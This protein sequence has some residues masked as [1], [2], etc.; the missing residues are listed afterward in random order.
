[1]SISAY[2]KFDKA[3]RRISFY[4]VNMIACHIPVTF[5]RLYMKFV[6]SQLTEEEKKQLV[7]RTGIYNKLTEIHHLTDFTEILPYGTTGEQVIAKDFSLPPRTE[8]FRHTSYFYALS[9]FV[10]CCNAN[11]RMQYLFGDVTEFPKQPTFVKSRPING[12]SVNAIVMKLDGIRHFM[13]LNDNTPWLK[14]KNMVVSRNYV[15]QPHRKLLLHTWFGHKM[16][17]FGQ[18]NKDVQ[19]GHPEWIQPFMTIE[20][21]L[22][23]KFIMCTEGNDVATNLKWVMSSNSIAVMPKPK[24]ET[25][26]MESTLIADYHYI[27]VK[28][29]YSDLIDK[30]QYYIEHTDEAKAIIRNA[31]EYVEQFKNKRLELAIQLSVTQR[32]FEYVK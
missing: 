20:D 23:Y 27:E 6:A 26:Y 32:Y 2:I 8:R 29:D 14:K 12:D 7:I 16:C 4:I 24:Y 1:M 3:K 22:K 31:H 13:F 25:W 5:L 11:G 30:V 15:S 28:D 10:R 17:D 18:T 9:P 19:D 21:Q